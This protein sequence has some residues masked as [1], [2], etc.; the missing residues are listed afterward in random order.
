MGWLR[1][2]LTAGRLGLIVVLVAVMSGVAAAASSGGG[3]VIHACANK[4]TGVLRIITPGRKGSAGRCAKS[5]RAL[6]WNTQ[7]I[8]GPTGPAGATGAQGPQGVPGPAGGK[9]S[10]GNP[11]PG[12]NETSYTLAVGQTQPL[13]TFGPFDFTA[14]CEL[15]SGETANT[16]NETNSSLLTVDETDFTPP[17]TISVSPGVGIP[18]A[19]SAAQE[20]QVIAS[21]SFAQRHEEDT[22]TSPAS[23][24]GELILTIGVGPSDCTGSLLWIPATST[25][26]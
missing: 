12:A 4:R 18:A 24:S 16:L 3:A 14:V 19:T 26:S 22:V 10:Q 9:G 5:E 7:G 21:S 17:A 6:S 8:R 23:D 25:Q 1:G 15:S 2:H 20:F 13:G 11:G